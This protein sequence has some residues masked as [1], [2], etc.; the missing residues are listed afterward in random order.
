MFLWSIFRSASGG[1][2][3]GVAGCLP[4][5][6]RPVRSLVKCGNY[7][8]GSPFVKGGDVRTSCSLVKCG[9]QWTC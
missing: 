9:N 1:S 4:G 7:S 6:L 5:S 8:T 3:P 2:L